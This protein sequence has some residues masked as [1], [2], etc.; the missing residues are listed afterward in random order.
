MSNCIPPTRYAAIPAV[1]NA[2]TASRRA[3]IALS[4]DPGNQVLIAQARITKRVELKTR[5]LWR[6]DIKLERIKAKTKALR[7]IR[8]ASQIART[9]RTLAPAA[10]QRSARQ[11][12]RE[13]AHAAAMAKRA[14]NLECATA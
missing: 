10:A 14:A 5:Y 8:Y 3:R 6:E 4:V 9:S 2:I 7:T 13:L 12:K 11:V 1:N